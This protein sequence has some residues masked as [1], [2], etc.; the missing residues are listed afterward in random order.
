MY[1]GMELSFNQEHQALY[2]PRCPL[3][4]IFWVDRSGSDNIALHNTRMYKCHT[5]VYPTSMMKRSRG[6]ILLGFNASPLGWC[7]L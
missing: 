7:T 4:N 5:R 1:E 2:V 3:I 6:M